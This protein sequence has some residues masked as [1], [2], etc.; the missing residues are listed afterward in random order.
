MATIRD[1]CVIVLLSAFACVDMSVAAVLD[2]AWLKGFTDKNPVSYGVGEEIV[3]TVTPENIDEPL[4][5]GAFLLKWRRSGDDG[6][7]DT[8][9]SPF[10]GRSPLVYRT[11]TDRPGFVRFEVYVCNADGSRYLQT[12]NGNEGMLE[13]RA[14][15]NRFEKKPHYVFFDGGAG[16]GLGRIKPDPAPC[17][18]DA[19]WEKQ[20]SRLER[21]PLLSRREV[22]TNPIPGDESRIEAVEIACAGLRPVTG[23][24]IRPTSAAGEKFPIRLQFFGYGVSEHRPP[25]GRYWKDEIVFEVNA[26]GIPLA[27]LGGTESDLKAM[28]SRICSNGF[29]YARDPVENADPETA[30]FNG[31]VLRVKRALQYAKTLSDW[32]GKDLIASGG[33][34]GALQALW[35]AGCGEGVSEVDISIPWC[36][37]IRGNMGRKGWY[38]A[39]TKA[40]GYYDAI[41]WARRIPNDCFVNITR[42]GLGDYTCPPMGIVK[43]WNVMTCP[44]RL[45]WVQGSQHGYIP[46]QSYEGRDWVW[47]SG[48]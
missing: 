24:V 22:A 11:R 12:Y 13:G 37:D 15:M 29:S 46:C 44:K 19:F 38:L 31:M 45:T 9:K 1:R 21:I 2:R 41:N 25:C 6:V 39:W 10:D 3:F 14:A 27:E 18:F 28:K 32:N 30:Y 17:D 43:L 20:F 42:A 33:S 26:H 23:Y 48:L 35:A 34:Q 40:L 5:A 7:V 36:C 8:G 47:T 16:A 4:P